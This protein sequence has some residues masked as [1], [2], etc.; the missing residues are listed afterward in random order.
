[1]DTYK[2]KWTQLQREI[3]KLMCIKAGQEL[4][5]REISRQIKISPT[6]I[7]KSIK[8]LEK[9]QLLTI[10]RSKTINLLLISINRNNQ[11]AIEEKRIENLR[12]IYESGFSEYLHYE[13]PGTTIILFGSYSL[14]MDT[15]NENHKSD[16]DIAIIGAKDKEINLSKFEKIF[17]REIRINFYDSWSAI[18]KHLKD[19][20]L[21]GIILN[22]SIEL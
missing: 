18:H 13:F 2:V 5:I 16:I 11:R 22:G 21:N 9:Y 4:N 8:E 1:M 3:F 19:N 10:K 14:G 7:S 15:Q 20:I 12:S 6:A 17:E